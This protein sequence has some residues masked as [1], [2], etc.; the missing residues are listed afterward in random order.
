[1]TLPECD[2]ERVAARIRTIWRTAE[3]VPSHEPKRELYAQLVRENERD[4]IIM[5]PGDRERLEAAARRAT[6]M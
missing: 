2:D 6:G 4:F 5:T 1:M 3:A